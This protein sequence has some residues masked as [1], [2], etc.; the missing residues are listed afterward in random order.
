MATPLNELTASEVAAA[1]NAGKTTCEAVTRA[2]IDRIAARDKQVQAWQYFDPEQ[3]LAAARALDRSGIKG[4][5]LGVPFNVT[6]PAPALAVRAA[7]VKPVPP[8]ANAVTFNVVY[9]VVPLLTVI[10]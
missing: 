1:V 5:L 10:I 8:A 4:P 9:G 2:C 6:V 3:A 7:A